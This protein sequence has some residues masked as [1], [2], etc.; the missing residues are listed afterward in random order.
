MRQYEPDYVWEEGKSYTKP[1]VNASDAELRD[2]SGHYAGSL[3][4]LLNINRGD[5]VLTEA[6]RQHLLNLYDAEIAFVDTHIGE[7]IAKIRRLGLWDNTMVIVSSDHGE[8]FGEHGYY[9]HGYSIYE[10]EVRVPLVIKPPKSLA[11]GKAV[12]GPVRNIDIMPTVL[13]YCGIP[14][15]AD[16]QGQSLRSYIETGRRPYLATCI[17]THRLHTQTHLLGYRDGQDKLIY[18]LSNGGV[19]LYH[20]A[21]DPAE[22]QNLLLDDAA[23]ETRDMQDHLEQTLLDML[24]VKALVALKLGDSPRLIDPET[25]EQLKALGYIY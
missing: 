11:E 3:V 8:A 21:T 25:R 23:R 24:G 16:I 7:V 6:E 12:D 4:L 10:E 5:I 17:E 1:K 13:D 19:E 9:Y 20:L 18:N 22:R 14:L 2:S 15:P